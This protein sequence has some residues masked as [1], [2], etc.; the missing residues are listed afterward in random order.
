[1]KHEYTPEQY[2]R[3]V[4]M[5]WAAL[6]ETN[7]THKTVFER[8]ADELQA[9]RDENK[10]LKA[11]TDQLEEEKET[12]FVSQTWGSVHLHGAELEAVRW[13]VETFQRD[14]AKIPY[15]DPIVEQASKALSLDA[16]EPKPKPDSEGCESCKDDYLSEQCGRCGRMIPC[17]LC[18]APA[19]QRA[20][21]KKGG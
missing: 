17:R 13:C 19:S 14:L 18:H 7:V 20:G 2:H 15:V 1:M 3:I 6:G 9:L 21:V 16:P 12:A 10:R 8:V 5:M 4:D 11:W